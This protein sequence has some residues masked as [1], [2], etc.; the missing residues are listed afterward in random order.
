MPRPT[1]ELAASVRGSVH[2]LRIADPSLT[3][4]VCTYTSPASCLAGWPGSALVQVAVLGSVPVPAR[5]CLIQSAM[6]QAV[7]AGSYLAANTL[8]TPAEVS[9]RTVAVP[10]TGSAGSAPVPVTRLPASTWTTRGAK[11]L[12]SA[13]SRDA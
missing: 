1:T 9:P 4:T 10:G 5:F 7:S 12:A 8:C 13:S 2:V 6:C 3:L 11:V